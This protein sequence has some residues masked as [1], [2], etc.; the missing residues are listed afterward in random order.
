[1]SKAPYRVLRIVLGFLSSLLALAGVLLIFSDKALIMRMLMHPP[2]SE[3][4]TLLLA[5]LKEM[6]G[7]ALALSVMLF[8]ASR[9]P[10]GNVAI[11]DGMTA[12]LCILAITPLISLYTLDVQRLYPAY[13]IWARSLVRLALAGVLYYL[14]PREAHWKPVGSF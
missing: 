8:L 12:G 9:D 10:V 14:R 4:S 11:I 2:A 7:L 3:I 13:L 5:A 6:G 1:M